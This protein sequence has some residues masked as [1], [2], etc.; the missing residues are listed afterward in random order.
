MNK[1][2]PS[3]RSLV[4]LIAFMGSCVGLTVYLWLAFGGP[5]PLKPESY[6]IAIP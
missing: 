3:L 4:V 6:R 2:P 5:L 1:R